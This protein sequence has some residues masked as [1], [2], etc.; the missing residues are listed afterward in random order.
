[1]YLKTLFQFVLQSSS[2]HFFEAA[3]VKYNDPHSY[4]AAGLF[5]NLLNDRNTN[6]KSSQALF[7][8]SLS[9]SN[10]FAKDMSM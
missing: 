10:E 8:V 7:L 1:M 4:L 2:C 5:K 9:G 6:R 3:S